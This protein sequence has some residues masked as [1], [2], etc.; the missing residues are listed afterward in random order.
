M[1]FG[2]EKQRMRSSLGGVERGQ[3]ARR[4]NG[5]KS[6]LPLKK[7]SGAKTVGIPRKR[8][9]SYRKKK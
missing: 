8:T 2:S 7:G 1:G 4:L 9:G 6:N 3:D 5:G